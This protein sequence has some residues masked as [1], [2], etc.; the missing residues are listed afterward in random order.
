[1]YMYMCVYVYIC[2]YVYV[3]ICISLICCQRLNWLDY[4]RAVEGCQQEWQLSTWVS[5]APLPIAS[6]CAV[7]GVASSFYAPP[8]SKVVPYPV[9]GLPAD[10]VALSLFI[11]QGM[12]YQLDRIAAPGSNHWFKWGGQVGVTSEALV[13]HAQPVK[14][15]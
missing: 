10:T 2:I 8:A 1:M 14:W 9:Q 13:K 3:Y 5:G 15:E 4:K 12:H 7:R 11:N 6:A